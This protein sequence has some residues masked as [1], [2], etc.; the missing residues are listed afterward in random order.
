MAPQNNISATAV[1]R[2]DKVAKDTI[3]DTVIQVDDKLYSA[4]RLAEMHP[5]GILM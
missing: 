1:D 2:G 5:G 4:H 3:A